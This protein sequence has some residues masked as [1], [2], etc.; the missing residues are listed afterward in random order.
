[1]RFIAQHLCLFLL[2]NLG[3]PS[4]QA[5]ETNA[6][7][8]SL[9]SQW[10]AKSAEFNTLS[11]DFSQER[12][13]RTMKRPL[14]RQGKLWVAQKNGQLRWQIDEPASLL[15][16]RQNTSAPLLWIDYKKKTWREINPTNDDSEANLQALPFIQNLQGTSIDQFETSFI[17]RSATVIKEQPGYWRVEMDMRERR[18]ALAIVDVFFEIHPDSGVLSLMEFRLRDSSVL[19]TRML[20]IEKNA[21]LDPA[22]FKADLSQL[23][24]VP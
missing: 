17:L 22:L 4:L 5:D 3:L 24:Q 11:I 6:E 13:L 7:A 15:L 10:L 1:M 19:K 2:L 16:L 8:R 21:V 12:Q 20:R 9:V 18:A 14:I 23:T